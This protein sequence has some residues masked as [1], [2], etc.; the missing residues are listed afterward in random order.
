M[1]IWFNLMNFQNNIDEAILDKKKISQ[2]NFFRNSHKKPGILEVPPPP[3]SLENVCL[4]PY[5]G[6]PWDP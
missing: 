1:T 2:R 5:L 6:T 3:N 4:D